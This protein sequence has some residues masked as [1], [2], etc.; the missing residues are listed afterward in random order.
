MKASEVKEQEKRGFWSRYKFLILGLLK[1]IV[2]NG[3]MVKGIP[4]NGDSSYTDI[5]TK[6]T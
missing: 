3:I 6:R 5:I 2:K 1:D 4:Q